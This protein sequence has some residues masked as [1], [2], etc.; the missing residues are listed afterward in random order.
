MLLTL[1]PLSLHLQR[2][3]VA[4]IL[5]NRPHTLGILHLFME[6][7]SALQCDKNR[8]ACLLTSLCSTNHYESVFSFC[9]LRVELYLATYK[10]RRVYDSEFITF[11]REIIQFFYLS[12]FNYNYNL[13][14]FFFPSLLHIL[15]L[16][17]LASHTPC[18]VLYLWA[19]NNSCLQF[20][21]KLF[22]EMLSMY[23]F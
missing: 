11:G 4:G 19:S 1:S 6:K 17:F 15:F 18:L 22:S 8:A 21:L 2:F 9:L 7:A 10:V 23:P 12:L 14:S 16:C 5:H 13:S 3:H 20:F